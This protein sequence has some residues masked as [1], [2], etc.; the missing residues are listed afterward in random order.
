M[1]ELLQALDF[2]EDFEETRIQDC[3]KLAVET[4]IEVED[5]EESGVDFKE[6][7]VGLVVVELVDALLVVEL[8]EVLLVVVVVV[9]GGR[10]T[11]LLKS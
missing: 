2:T 9:H 8:V 11:S 6:L 7:T 4:V 3:D 10:T 5:F 1:L